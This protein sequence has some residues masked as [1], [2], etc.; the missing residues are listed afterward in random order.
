[1]TDWHKADKLS[2]SFITRGRHHM[3]APAPLGL[4]YITTFDFLPAC[5]VFTD[6]PLCQVNVIL[7]RLV[8]KWRW[9]WVS[10]ICFCLFHLPAAVRGHLANLTWGEYRV[11]MRSLQIRGRDMLLPFSAITL[12]HVSFIRLSIQQL[13]CFS[14]FRTKL[15]PAANCLCH[16]VKPKTLNLFCHLIR[17]RL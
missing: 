2:P 4:Y 8:W 10:Y 17:C 3:A 16:K 15:K 14:S 5:Q 6:I 11:L 9:K 1:M 7:K 12:L 13:F